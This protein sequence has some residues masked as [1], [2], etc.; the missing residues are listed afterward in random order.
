MARAH[1]GQNIWYLTL[2]WTDLT[3]DQTKIRFS[4]DDDIDETPPLRGRKI[5][6]LHK[7]DCNTNTNTNTNTNIGGYKMAV[8]TRS[9]SATVK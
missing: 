5:V 4:A 8:V 1:A 6:E 2:I 9:V 7:F 3:F